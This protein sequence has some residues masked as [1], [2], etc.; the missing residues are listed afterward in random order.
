R[1]RLR[2]PGSVSA[3]GSTVEA[4]E[5]RRA[6]GAAIIHNARRG[7]GRQRDFQH[8]DELMNRTV[9]VSVIVA[10]VALVLI[11]SSTFFVQQSQNAVVVRFGKLI[12][13]VTNE[14]G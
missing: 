13:T 2:R 7:T 11:Y 9:G 10:V 12:D 3:A 4:A 6:P 14:P 8:G 1:H 5:G